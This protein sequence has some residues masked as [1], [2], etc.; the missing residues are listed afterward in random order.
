MLF[1][2]ALIPTAI[3]PSVFSPTDYPIFGNNDAYLPLHRYFFAVHRLFL[4]HLKSKTEILGVTLI[5]A[6]TY[7]PA[8]PDFCPFSSIYCKIVPLR[9]SLS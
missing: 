7:S 2:E 1:I 3:C 4:P 6:Y 8:C 9:A 5:M